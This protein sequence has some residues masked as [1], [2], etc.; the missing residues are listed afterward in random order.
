MPKKKKHSTEQYDAV[1][2]KLIELSIPNVEPGIR[3]IYTFGI[4][5]KAI[6]N[7]YTPDSYTNND[8]KG[9]WDVVYHGDGTIHGI[10]KHIPRTLWSV[11][12]GKLTSDGIETK[13]GGLFTDREYDLS[14]DLIQFFKDNAEHI[15]ARSLGDYYEYRLH[16]G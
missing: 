2:Q 5:H 14:D 8:F 15:T 6:K 9:M 11:E 4:M 1:V 12:G 13:D 3:I 10:A 7:G 16:H